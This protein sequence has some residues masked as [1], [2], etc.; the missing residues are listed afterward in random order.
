MGRNPLGERRKIDLKRLR[1]CRNYHQLCA[2]RLNKH[3]IFREKRRDGD[4]FILP[5]CGQCTEAQGQGCCS[6]HRH[7]KIVRRKMRSVSLIQIIRNGLPGGKVS[8]SRCIPMQADAVQSLCQFPNGFVHTV[9]SWNRRVPQRKII[10][11]LYADHL[12]TLFA[13]FKQLT[14]CRALTAQPIHIFCYDHDCS[15]LRHCSNS[16][17][18]ILF[19]A[20]VFSTHKCRVSTASDT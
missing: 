8:L 4:K 5:A 3:P 19:S 20:T 14:D 7:V 6:S 2:C 10:D 11:I 17:S 16:S 15:S 9:R 1:V 18:L 13:I 12:G